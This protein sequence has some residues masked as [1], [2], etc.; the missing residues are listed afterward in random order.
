MVK[1]DVRH[2]LGDDVTDVEIKIECENIY[3]VKTRNCFIESSGS[4]VMTFIK[5][6]SSAKG[7]TDSSD[8]SVV[9]VKKDGIK[10]DLTRSKETDIVLYY[11]LIIADTLQPSLL[12][13]SIPSA[14]LSLIPT[15]VPSASLMPS[16][17]PTFDGY[18]VNKLNDV[19]EANNKKKWTPMVKVDVR[20]TLGD[21]V[22]DVEIK[23]ECENIYGVKTRNCFIESSG[24]CV[25][26][27]IKINS[28]AKGGTDSSDCSVVFVKKDG[29]KYDLTRSKE[30]DIVLYYPL[31]DTLQPSLLPS[32]PP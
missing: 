12:P 31:I 24:S 21:D 1:V 28:S 4:C 7:G 11:P 14:S 27:F 10:Y 17:Q 18:F 29:I 26:T 30:T 13:S 19:S 23:I 16:L 8:C 3:G 5:I 25:M 20:H 22:T 9:F 6:N 32:L 2:T 15:T